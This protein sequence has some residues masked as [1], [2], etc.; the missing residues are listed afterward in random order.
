[1]SLS[2]KVA[3]VTGGSEGIGKAAARSMA[4]EGASVAICA[5]RLDVLEKA[6]EEIRTATGGDGMF[7]QAD[8]SNA[9]GGKALFDKVV[10]AHGGVS[11]PEA[12]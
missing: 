1:M 9:D 2:G 12:G 7:V 6:A 5:R 3:I 8:V 11:R 4:A 10:G